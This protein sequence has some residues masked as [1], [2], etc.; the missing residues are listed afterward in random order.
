[1]ANDVNN[2][3]RCGGDGA[4]IVSNRENGPVVVHSAEVRILGVCKLAVCRELLANN[5]VLTSLVSRGGLERGELGT[6]AEPQHS[7]RTSKRSKR[8][9]LKTI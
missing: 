6:I 4:E 3:R 7:H 8:S 2:R 9:P 5:D 1:M